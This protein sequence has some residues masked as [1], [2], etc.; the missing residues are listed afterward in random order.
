MEKSISNRFYFD[1]NATSPLASKV[2]NFL[3]NGDFLFGN[4]SSI[5]FEGKHAK[6]FINDCRDYLFELF[7]LSPQGYDLFFHSGATESIN[8]YFKGNALRLFKEKKQGLF[9]FSRVD[10]AAVNELREHLEI[11]G[12]RVDYFEV[13][14]QGQFDLDELIKRIKS[15]KENSSEVFLNFT[16]INNE[17][18]V[19]WPLSIAS[20]IKN[21]KA[22]RAVG[23]ANGKNP[24][25][26]VV[27]CH[28]VIAA[29]GSIGGYSAGISIKKRLLKLE[30]IA[31]A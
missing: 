6:K 11:L 12:H 8:L 29:D 27:P 15:S 18:G 24:V 4:P 9:L 7:E 21:P 13:D 14:H 17:T 10:H 30:E 23:S 25:C 26:I 2:K 28:R 19:V 1:Y 3:A 16:Y 20:K 31:L 5:H 22:V